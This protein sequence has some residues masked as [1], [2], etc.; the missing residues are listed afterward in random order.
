MWPLVGI[1]QLANIDG[2]VGAQLHFVVAGHNEVAILV[3]M[4]CMIVVQSRILIGL[5][6]LV[7]KRQSCYNF[8]LKQ[9]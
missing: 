4:D 9:P 1:A 5:P 7:C 8:G 2:P 3:Q 6:S